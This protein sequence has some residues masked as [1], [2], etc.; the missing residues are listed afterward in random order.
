[1][2]QAQ[3]IDWSQLSG[4]QLLLG[5][6]AICVAVVL[7]HVVTMVGEAKTSPHEQETE[8]RKQANDAEIRIAQITADRDVELRQTELRYELDVRKLELDLDAEPDGTEAEPD[9]QAV[10][11]DGVV[12]D[13]AP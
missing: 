10:P 6:A 3:G 12:T 7:Y 11:V 1:M 2:N 8:R 13:D 4:A 9:R 5:V